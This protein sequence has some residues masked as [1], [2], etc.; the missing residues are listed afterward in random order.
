MQHVQR[1]GPAR[2]PRSPRGPGRPARR[3]LGLREREGARRRASRR[4]PSAGTPGRVLLRLNRRLQTE[5][6]STSLVRD[7][8][9]TVIA[10]LS[11][12]TCLP[13][14]RRSGPRRSP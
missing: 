2:R 1:E 9:G 5:S 10:A 13:A 12:R 6:D 4:S 3:L 11:V 14:A 7:H 8:G